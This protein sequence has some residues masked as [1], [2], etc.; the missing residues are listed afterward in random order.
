MFEELSHVKLPPVAFTRSASP[1]NA[2]LFPMKLTFRS[3]LLVV[4]VH[5]PT[6][7]HMKWIFQVL[8]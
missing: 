2:W 1:V 7:S 5:V 3:W 6:S 8:F 4:Q